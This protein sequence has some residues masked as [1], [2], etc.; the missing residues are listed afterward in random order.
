[1]KSKLL[2]S[3]LLATVAGAAS[4]DTYVVSSDKGTSSDEPKLA[5]SHSVG[6]CVYGDKAVQLGDTVIMAESNIVLVCANASQGPVF[7]PLASSVTQRV[8][9]AVPASKLAADVNGGSYKI[10]GAATPA[11]VP[12]K[13]WDDGK[14]TFI[15]LPKP[16]SGEL[17]IV[18]AQAEDGSDQLVNYQWEE[19]NSRFVVQRLLDRA[20]L[21]LGEKRVLV[22][23]S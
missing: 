7:Y 3:L 6:T 19:S 12:T 23:R 15:E 11:F 14:V 21:V 9:A 18:L 16:F 20:V 2:L 8:I 10:S 13:I 1:M 22:T 17:P 5:A 4:A